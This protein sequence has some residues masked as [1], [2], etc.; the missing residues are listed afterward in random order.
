MKKIITVNTILCSLFL[1]LFLVSC[2]SSYGQSS[3]SS[4]Q[5]LQFWP[6]LTG[7][8]AFLL[9]VLNLYLVNKL[10]GYEKK[11]LAE[12]DRRFEKAATYEQLKHLEEIVLIKIEGIKDHIGFSKVLEKLLADGSIK[13]N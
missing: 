9:G 6:V 13:S 3:S 8:L 7:V 1:I 10:N 11:I 5:P 4:L 2:V 12:V